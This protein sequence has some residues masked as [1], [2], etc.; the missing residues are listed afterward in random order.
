MIC[1]ACGRN[2]M[3]ESAN[4]CDYC[5]TSLKD[6]GSY[7]I[8]QE[9]HYIK[10]K[11]NQK[12]AKTEDEKPISFGNWIGTMLLPF[13]PIFGGLAYIVMLFVW[14]FGNET[15]KSKK[16]W[17]RATLIVTIISIVILIFFIA[18]TMM[19]VMNS[20]LSLE[21]YMEQQYY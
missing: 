8:N 21:A 17:A 1:N 7:K 2:S 4:Y 6:S 14:A 15:S 9:E 16:N 20:G 19:D 12:E 3:N 5:G 11:E 13:I 18:S 10:S